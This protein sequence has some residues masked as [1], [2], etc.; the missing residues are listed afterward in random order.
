MTPRTPD[1]L[2]S[3]LERPHVVK[4]DAE[5]SD[6]QIM[7]S[8]GVLLD[9]R[10]PAVIVELRSDPEVVELRRLLERNY[11]FDRLAETD[12]LLFPR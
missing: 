3:D 1:D 4:V 11:A 9:R 2:A 7:A 10:R 12:W 8:T 5:G 6:V